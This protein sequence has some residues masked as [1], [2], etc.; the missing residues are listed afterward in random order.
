MTA[1]ALEYLGIVEYKWGRPIEGLYIIPDLVIG[2]KQPET[3]IVVSH[4]TT[5][6]SGTMKFWRNLEELFE[7]KTL[8]SRYTT[9]DVWCVNLVFCCRRGWGENLEILN[10][11]FDSSLIVFEKSYWNKL[12]AFL[13][14]NL[15]KVKKLSKERTKLF[16]QTKL[17]KDP[18]ALSAFEGFS[19]DLGKCL[20]RTTLP[21]ELNRLWR[22]ETK[23]VQSRKTQPRTIMNTFY[24]RGLSKCLALTAQD[25]LLVRG[26]VES[27]PSNRISNQSER[28]KHL[29]NLGFLKETPSLAGSILRV[30][31]DIEFV[32]KNLDLNEIRKVISYLMEVHGESLKAYLTDLVNAQSVVKMLDTIIEKLKIDGINEDT[33]LKIFESCFEKG[34]YHGLAN[35]RV[36]PMDIILQIIRT[37]LDK[38]FSEVVLKE[39]TRIPSS[40]GINPIDF[41]IRRVRSINEEHLYKIAQFLSDRLNE[42]GL[43]AIEQNSRKIIRDYLKNRVNNLVK[44]KSINPLHALIALRLT[45]F[46][47]RTT[48]YP[49]KRIYE[50]CC[51]SPYVGVRKNTGRTGITFSIDLPNKKRWIILSMA[52]YGGHEADKRKELSSRVRTLRYRWDSNLGLFMPRDDVER[53]ILVLDGTWIKAGENPEE[54]IEMLH[55]A[56]WDVILFPHQLQLLADQIERKLIKRRS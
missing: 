50:T 51:F 40:G 46:S 6:P 8:R 24:R 9:R 32:I 1:C 29:V 49:S 41:Y 54:I 12:L 27:R 23:F 53:R 36:W 52:A 19:K 14:G 39:R 55:E 26:L 7:V 31:E 30:D 10:N 20:N 35:G 21:R 33:L 25:L 42:I 37:C 56:G 4:A 47:E 3:I 17:A 2:K 43:A 18:I 48:G 16:L 45:P 22:S 13:H 34:S 5:V 44:H 38:R 28:I 11:V 15:K